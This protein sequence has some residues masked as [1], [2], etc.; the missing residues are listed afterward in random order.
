MTVVSLFPF[1]I[2]VTFRCSRAANLLNK[3]KIK[4]KKEL[5]PASFII[6]VFS[7]NNLAVVS[8]RKESEI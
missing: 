4:T 2:K 7:T 8:R 1:L 6:D 5:L 3:G